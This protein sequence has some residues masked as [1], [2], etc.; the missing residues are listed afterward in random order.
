MQSKLIFLLTVPQF[1]MNTSRSQSR[2]EVLHRADRRNFLTDA[3]VS[4][5]IEIA[6]AEDIG[7]GDVTTESI[8]NPEARAQA[9]FLA[10]QSGV[11]C[12]L[13]LVEQVFQAVIRRT[14]LDVSDEEVA[15]IYELF[16]WETFIEEGSRV[17]AG[18][19]I[20]RI[21]G[22][23]RV[24]LLAE[25]TALNF[26][27]RMSG[28]ATQ[29]SMYASAVEGT[30][31]QVIDTRKT[32]PGWRLLDKYAVRMG[33]GANHRTG[34]YDMA[35]IK[36]NHRDAAGGI[37]AALTLCNDD[38]NRLPAQQR[39]PIEV[40]T[41]TLEDVHEVLECLE[42]GLA[43]H[44]VMFD[45]FSPPQVRTA[46]Q[47]VRGAIETEASGGITLHNIREYAETGVDFI[48]VGALTHSAAAL[49]ISMKFT[50]RL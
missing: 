25:R 22:N 27:Q 16:H 26:L 11:I 14:V 40:E 18:T 36:D 3:S 28:V 12:G 19:E 29:T 48:S 47:L 39:F 21:E 23:A 6:L 34:L 31:A 45:N 33:G 37:T 15:Q 41:R 9:F 10:K 50:K 46:V 8:I 49:D 35:M 43:V 13:Q 5:L 44:R 2:H 17:L 4:R 32:I 30:G 20:A 24:L 1:D 38:R 7:T 42:A